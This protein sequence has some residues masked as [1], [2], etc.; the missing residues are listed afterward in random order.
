MPS[1]R[2]SSDL[3]LHRLSSSD[4]EIKLKAIREVKNQIIG[5]RTKKLSYIKLGAVPAVADALAKANAD[6]DFGS[7]LIVQSA[8]VLG[9][10]ACGVDQ[11]V[12]A[13]LDAGAFP[14]LIRLLSAVDEKVNL[15]N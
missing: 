4:Y 14:N 2:P 5:N 11:G 7:N 8:A 10:F 13:V 12:R 3:I 15:I 6:S 9:S 1:T